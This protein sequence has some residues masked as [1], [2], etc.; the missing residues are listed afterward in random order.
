MYIDTYRYIYIYI[1][2]YICI[3]MCIYIYIRNHFLVDSVQYRNTSPRGFGSGGK[4]IWTHCQPGGGEL[5]EPERGFF[6]DDLLVRI[7]Y[8]IVMIKWTGLAPWEFEF[9]FPGSLTST[10]LVRGT[11]PV[12]PQTVNLRI[13]W[14][15]TQLRQS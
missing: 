15:S 12:L 3:Y 13:V 14:Q 2:M 9:P 11:K 5:G 4:T 8:I 7:H 6:I 10:F 1:Y